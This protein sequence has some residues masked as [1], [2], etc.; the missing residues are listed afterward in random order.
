[1]NPE[2]SSRDYQL[3]QGLVGGMKLML[4]LTQCCDR[5]MLFAM[6]MES[7]SIRFAVLATLSRNLEYEWIRHD[8]VA[9]ESQVYLGRAFH[10]LQ[11]SIGHNSISEVAIAS[12]FLLTLSW[13]TERGVTLLSHLHA[14]FLCLQYINRQQL[15]LTRLPWILHAASDALYESLCYVGLPFPFFPEVETGPKLFE[16]VDLGIDLLKLYEPAESTDDLT[17]IELTQRRLELFWR[18][19]PALFLG[20]ILVRRQHDSAEYLDR[21]NRICDR[22][23]KYSLKVLGFDGPKPDS[24]VLDGFLTDIPAESVIRRKYPML[25]QAYIY[26][27]NRQQA[28][29]YA[30]CGVVILRHIVNDLAPQ[31]LLQAK[32]AL[33]KIVVVSELNNGAF[34]ESE[35]FEWF[36][37][38]WSQVLISRGEG[39]A[40]SRITTNLVVYGLEACAWMRNKISSMASFREESYWGDRWQYFQGIDPELILASQDGLKALCLWSAI[41]F[42]SAR[43][44]HQFPPRFFNE[45]Q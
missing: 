15:S 24:E 12:R 33:R 5:S 41:C 11:K 7:P 32:K 20:Y 35:Q 17:T 36:A 2:I 26:D 10:Y 9:Q 1:M 18:I 28:I 21:L 29:P 40:W 8:N 25:E 14:F 38:I 13:P 45:V 30:I 37:C 4:Y 42:R 3:L 34:S 16:V 31:Y 44:D 39:L 23:L 43:I 6:A 27:S 19:L 22:F